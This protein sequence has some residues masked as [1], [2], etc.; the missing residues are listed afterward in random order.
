MNKCSSLSDNQH[1]FLVSLSWDHLNRLN[2]CAP[3]MSTYLLGADELGC[4]TISLKEQVLELQVCSDGDCP[5]RSEA[6]GTDCTVQ[7]IKNPTQKTLHRV[8]APPTELVGCF[9]GQTRDEISLN[10]NVFCLRLQ[11]APSVRRCQIKH[12]YASKNLHLSNNWNS[13]GSR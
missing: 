2:S 6:V 12:G 5:S 8:P 4:Q 7:G 1:Q 11:L 13:G 10:Q 3:M 9:V